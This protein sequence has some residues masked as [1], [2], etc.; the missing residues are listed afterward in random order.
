MKEDT[1]SA[2]LIRK[3]FKRAMGKLMVMILPL[4]RTVAALTDQNK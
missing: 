1:V 3:H 2:L 4:Q